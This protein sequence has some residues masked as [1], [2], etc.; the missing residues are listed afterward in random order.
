MRLVKRV[1]MLALATAIPLSAVAA[2]LDVK[3]VWSR[4]MPPV[5]KVGAAYLQ[6][7]NSGEK[8]P[9][10]SGA[11]SDVAGRVEMHT[12]KM[13]GGMMSMEQVEHID[14]PPGETVIFKPHGLH[15]MLFDLKRTLVAGEK[16]SVELEFADGT[17]V[18]T[19]A[20]IRN[21]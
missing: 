20:E 18:K 6:I 17:R 1:L 12:H 5:S 7:E 13:D 3:D 11:S 9:R 14:V 16:F 8:A 4:A 2:D 15:L 10:L 19:E 21:P